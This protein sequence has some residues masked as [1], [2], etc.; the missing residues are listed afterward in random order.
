MKHVPLGTLATLVGLLDK[1]TFVLLIQL[2]LNGLQALL[3]VRLLTEIKFEF[4]K[5]NVFKLNKLTNVNGYVAYK[6][7]LFKIKLFK[8]I[9]PTN[10]K[11]S[12]DTIC[13]WL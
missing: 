6:L 2:P 8:P 9:S 5:F 10:G 4:L 12:I 3:N 13:I 7:L 11:L 1:N